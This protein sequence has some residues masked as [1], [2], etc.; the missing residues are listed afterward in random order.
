MPD[1][2]AF[3]AAKHTRGPKGAKKERPNQRMVPRKS[4][5]VVP[6]LASLTT[7]LFGGIL[8]ANRREI[9]HAEATQM[10]GSAAKV[11]A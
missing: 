9:A 6:D 10:L 1:I 4:F 2:H 3:P 8:A 5:T 11:Y 7:W